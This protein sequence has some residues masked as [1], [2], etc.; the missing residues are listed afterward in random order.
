MIKL[1]YFL[2]VVNLFYACK[3]ITRNGTNVELLTT[4]QLLITSEHSIPF[5]AVELADEERLYSIDSSRINLMFIRNTGLDSTEVFCSSIECIFFSQ[6]NLKALRGYFVH[7]DYLILVL[8]E[9]T[10]LTRMDEKFV[11]IKEIIPNAC[12]ISEALPGIYAEPL[13]LRIDFQNDSLIS[14]ELIR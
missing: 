4:T 14:Y 7:N 12:Y 5:K 3:S 2:S 11:K 10:G 1:V 8:G 6:V 13:V 9:R